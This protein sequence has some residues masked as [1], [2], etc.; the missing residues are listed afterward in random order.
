ML[1][2]GGLDLP[3][4][5]RT[6][7][8]GMLGRV[9][10]N[11]AETLARYVSRL[12][13]SGVWNSC[14]RLSSTGQR[15]HGNVGRRNADALVDVP[16]WETLMTS[17]LAIGT[18]MLLALVLVTASRYVLS[19]RKSQALTPVTML[20][21]RSRARSRS[22]FQPLSIGDAVSHAGADYV[23]EDISSS[24][25]DGETS[26]MVHL[27]PRD[28][29]AADQ[30]LSISPGGTE[31][32]WLDAAAT[33]GAPGA[34]QLAL[35]GVVLPLM[36]AQTAVVKLRSARGSAPAAFASVWRYRA[37]PDGCDRGAV[38][39]WPPAGVCGPYRRPGPAA[40]SGL[41]LRHCG[42]PER[43]TKHRPR[44]SAMQRSWWTSTRCIR[45]TPQAS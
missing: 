2:G 39:G 7:M 13:W 27:V 35:G 30:W 25:A 32:A 42:L 8:L 16:I 14:G 21:P 10:A 29:L 43:V 11:L 1:G 31:L 3:P 19:Y 4:E 18:V 34:R 9:N 12:R 36:S 33:S 15:L 22:I 37:G 6:Q 41:P 45:R 38:L 17:S 5:R 26:R 24:F 44:G 23:V 40:T 20:G 28:G